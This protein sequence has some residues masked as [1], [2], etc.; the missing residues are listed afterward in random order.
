LHFVVIITAF[1]REPVPWG[2][3]NIDRF[4]TT[5]PVILTWVIAEVENTRGL[6]ATS[7]AVVEQFVD[8][9]VGFITHMASIQVAIFS[10]I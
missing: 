10:R 4:L 3:L 7:L 6:D 8:R 9:S 1:Y 5:V 2:F